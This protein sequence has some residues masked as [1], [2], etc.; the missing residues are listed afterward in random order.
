M[1]TSTASRR[2]LSIAPL[3]R[4]LIA[5][6]LL[7]LATLLVAGARPAAAATVVNLSNAPQ[8][9]NCGGGQVT[10]H[11]VINQIDPGTTISAFSATF[12]STGVVTAFTFDANPAVIHVFVTTTGDDTLT[13]ATATLSDQ[14]GTPRMVLSDF[15]CVPTV[16]K[17]GSK[18][19]DLN[20]NGA[21]DIGEP[22]LANWTIQA[23]QGG[24]VVA[25]TTTDVN[26]YYFFLLTPGTYTFQE[27]CP[28]GAGWRQSVPGPLTSAADCGANKITETLV[29]G[30]PSHDNNFGNFMNA[31]KSGSKFHDLNANSVWD[32]GEPGLAG[33]T[34]KAFH[35]MTEVASTT[36]DANGAYG[37]SLTP[38]SYSI[39]EVCPAGE[40]WRQSVPTPITSAATC[41][42]N[43]HEVTLTS[44]QVD[45]NNNFGNF[46]NATKSGH[47]FHDLNANGAWDAGEPGL[48]GWTIEALQGATVVASTTT[49][50]GGAYSFSLQP[51]AY[52]FREVCPA[53]AGWRQSV[54]GPITSAANCGANSIA[55]TLVSDTSYPDNNFGN[56]KNASKSGY[57]FHDLNKNGSWDAGE[58]ALPGWDSPPR[59]HDEWQRPV[60]IL[61]GPGQLRGLRDPQDRLDAD[62]SDRRDGR[63][64]RLLWPHRRRDGHAR[65]LG[66]G[67]HADLRPAGP[68]QQLREPL[69]VRGLH[70]W[71]LEGVPAPRLVDPDRL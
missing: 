16:L 31:T 53:G 62:V 71:L 35:G 6:A 2:S 22:G 54:P 1:P 7:A 3:Q 36:T 50:V 40:G 32:A 65:S 37:F 68:R 25:S 47:K 11:F 27:V 28:A 38:G 55:E 39:R 61:G 4:M 70:T 18:F 34:I 45:T 64:R 21:W 56:F 44:G 66:M 51:G 60:L 12:T 57:K 59:R 49:G 58:P 67:D 17:D 48:A 19:H 43:T 26:G 14:S 9:S 63:L 5:A 69:P 13:A 29:L 10:W 30:A 8:T 46:K 24:V 33:W 41:G 20:A 15:R 52:T 42:A 23:V